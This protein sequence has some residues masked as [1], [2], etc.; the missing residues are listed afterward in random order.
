ML[1]PASLPGRDEP[2]PVARRGGG[3]LLALCRAVGSGAEWALGVLT[4]VVGLGI[5]AA[6]PVAQF[7]SLGYLLEA[8]GRVARGGRLGAAAVGVRR[9]ARVGTVVAG[10]WLWLLPARFVAALAASAHWID[11]GGPVARRWRGILILVVGLT[12]VHL[13]ASC[14][15]G[16]RWRHFAWPVGSFAWLARRTRRGPLY[17][18]ARDA[19]CDFVRGLRLPH[20]F[21]L[22]MLGFAGSMAWLVGPVVCLILGRRVPPLGVVGGIGLGMV[23][24]TLPFLQVRFALEGRF[25]ALFELRGRPRAVSPRPLGLR[26][27]L[28]SVGGGRP[29]AVS[30]QDRDGPPRGG[31]L[32]GVLFIGLLFPARVACGWAYARGG[33]REGDRHWFARSTGRI[34]MIPGAVV[35]VLIVFLAQ[36]TSWGGFWTFFE[37]HAFL[38]PVPFPGY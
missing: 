14:A 10:C 5:L 30:A 27:G 19:T 29:A 15:R 23:A 17:A 13:A 2:S 24:L 22:G 1:E 26:A 7:L 16:G 31:R 4:L 3:R 18:S 38:I 12:L 35:Y 8:S 21:R 28:C 34:V 32:S 36:Y 25:G 20:Y 9:A 6:L 37:Q 33:L 11:P